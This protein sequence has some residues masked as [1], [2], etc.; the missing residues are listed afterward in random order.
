[1]LLILI[2]IA[3]TSLGNSNEYQQ[4]MLSE[5]S[6]YMHRGFNLKTKKLLDCKLI[7]ICVVIRSNMVGCLNNELFCKWTSKALIR[8]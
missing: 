8:L 4:H 6:R 2:C 7:R 5:R 1:M 3:L